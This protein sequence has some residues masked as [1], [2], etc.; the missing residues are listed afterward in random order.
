M[1]QE[2]VASNSEYPS[3]QEND[4][5]ALRQIASK[6]L[7]WEKLRGDIV[8]P[9]NAEVIKRRW[10]ELVPYI[11]VHTLYSGYSL[12]MINKHFQSIVQSFNNA[13][14]ITDQ[15]NFTG[16]AEKPGTGKARDQRIRNW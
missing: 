6:I 4:F 15:S 7:K 12:F 5:P 9:T 1:Q 14:T 8:E 13:P 2:F 10:G 11:R 3:D 16:R